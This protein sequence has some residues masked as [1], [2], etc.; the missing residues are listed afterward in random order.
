MQ[1]VATRCHKKGAKHESHGAVAPPGRRTLVIREACLRVVTSHLAVGAEHGVFP[2]AFLENVGLIILTPRHPIL[3]L[4]FL[5]AFL[6]IIWL[7]LHFYSSAVVCK[8]VLLDQILLLYVDR[9][10]LGIAFGFQVNVDE[11]HRNREQ[12]DPEIRYGCHADAVPLGGSEE[13][14]NIQSWLEAVKQLMVDEVDAVYCLDAKVEEEDDGPEELENAI[15]VIRLLILHYS[16]VKFQKLIAIDDIVALLR[17]RDL[18]LKIKLAHVL[19]YVVDDEQREHV[20]EY[21][22][23]VERD[24]QVVL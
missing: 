5:T 16:E 1:K 10:E 12:P 9:G 6:E 18:I 3:L 21:A 22:L 7:S 17:A 15:P 23:G 14:D 19:V 8:L 11:C 4:F 13:H 2:A 24:E 20:D